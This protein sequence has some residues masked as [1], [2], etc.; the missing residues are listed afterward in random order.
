M[1]DPSTKQEERHGKTLFIRNLPYTSTNEKLEKIFSDIGPIKTC[2]VVKDKESGKCRG[3]GYVKFTLLEDAE[4]ALK[5]IKKVEGRNV[6]IVYANKKEKKKRFGLP[7]ENEENKQAD[8]SSAHVEDKKQSKAKNTFKKKLVVKP[9]KGEKQ[10]VNPLNEGKRARLIIRNLSF[11]CSLEDLKKECEKYGTVLD[12]HIPKKSTGIKLGFGFVQFANKTQA[13]MA[14]KEMNGKSI[15]GRVVAVD[16]TLPKDKFIANRTI[17]QVE[18]EEEEKQ[19]DEEDSMEV[20]EEVSEKK[21]NGVPSQKTS[22]EDEEESSEENEEEESKDGASEEDDDNNDNEDSDDNEDS[23]DDDEELD[24][25][26]EESEDD[27]EDSDDDNENSEDDDEDSEED[28]DDKDVAKKSK[29]MDRESDVTEGRT[30]FVRNLPFNTAENELEDF[31]SQF[32]DVNYARTVYDHSTGLS[33]GSAFIQFSTKESADDC[34]KAAEDSVKGGLSVGERQ[35]VVTL[36]VS[37]QQA[38]QLI[39]KKEEKK[40]EPKDS[41]NLYLA[42]EGLIREGTE[43][44]EDVPPADMAMRSKI[45][46]ANRAKLKDQ[47][48][49]VSSTRLCVHNIPATVTD[50][51]LRKIVYQAAGDRSA[52]VTECRIMRD[53]NRLNSQGV[54]KSRGYAFCAFNKHEH[55]LKALHHLNNNKEIFGD[56]KRPIVEFSLENRKALEIKQKRIEKSQAKCKQVEA[57]LN[58]KSPGAPKGK[59]GGPQG[60]AHGTFQAKT[61]RASPAVMTKTDGESKKKWKRKNKQKLWKDTRPLDT[62]KSQDKV[63]RAMHKGPLGLPSHFGPKQRHKKRPASQGRE[64]GPKSNK[65]FKKEPR[66]QFVQGTNKTPKMKTFNKKKQFDEFDKMV[67]NYKQKIVAG[68]KS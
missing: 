26:K 7:K 18:K 12:V 20:D 41:R 35:L 39:Q 50:Q 38:S 57:S 48:I 62:M 16:W 40:A 36:A 64:H 15:N 23:E 42:R 22:S 60:K 24:D 1:A 53:L 19:S 6:H 14:V 25:D 34:I 31:F 8:E 17:K 63:A 46:A 58:R 61:P 47:N 54:G 29:A 32:G 65:K 5:T 59:S 33:R 28:E 11:K 10:P 2:F 67:A 68:F 13:G 43:A 4:K 44:A 9:Q 3:F 52:K 45:A 27:S 21:N 51:R 30:V 55:A 66:K 56:K 49:F 37:R